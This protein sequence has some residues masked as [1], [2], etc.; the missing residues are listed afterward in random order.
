MAASPMVMVVHNR[1][2]FPSVIRVQN[3]P[4]QDKGEE[5]IPVVLPKCKI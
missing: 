3:W 1:D 5:R 2:P 4:K